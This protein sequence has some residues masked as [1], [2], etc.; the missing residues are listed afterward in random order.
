MSDTYFNLLY[1]SQDQTSNYSSNICSSKRLGTY[2]K[3]KINIY[4]T[5]LHLEVILDC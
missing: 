4:M 3:S 5:G 1:F 2:L